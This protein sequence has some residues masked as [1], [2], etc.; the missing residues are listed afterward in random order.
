MHRKEIREA[1]LE[2][3]ANRKNERDERVDIAFV[4]KLVSLRQQVRASERLLINFITEVI[5]QPI[6]IQLTVWAYLLL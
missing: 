3:A 4:R 5:P 2:T 6:K 1:E